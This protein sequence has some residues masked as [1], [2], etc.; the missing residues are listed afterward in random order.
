MKPPFL[1]NEISDL[2]QDTGVELKSNQLEKKRIAFG[3]SGGIGAVETVKLIRELRRHGA[4]VTV[5]AN[6]D[7]LEFI[8]KTAL[9]WASSH[10]VFLGPEPS[11]DHLGGYD[12]TVVAPATLNTLS[13]CAL[14]LCDSMVS[15]LIASQLGLRKP[16][17][18][19]PSMNL[20]LAN[21]PMF[22]T[23]LK[24]LEDFGAKIWVN[25]AQESRLKMPSP[26]ELMRATFEC[27]KIT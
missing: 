16:I 15:L 3:I 20:A 10:A 1:D 7:A 13:K 4:Q 27:L 23:Y 24:K 6:P 26:E 5:F 25:N 21:H 12:L 17:L 11:V 2:L 14:G 18:F 9:E 19:F 8:G 22:D